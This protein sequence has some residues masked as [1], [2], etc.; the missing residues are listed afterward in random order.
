[1]YQPDYLIIKNF[2]SIKEQKFE[3]PKGRATL[4]QGVNLDEDEGESN[5]SG[6][7][8]LIEGLY[9][10]ITNLILRD[11]GL[12]M[13]DLIRNGCDSAEL[14]SY[15]TNTITKNT[16]LINREFFRKSSSKL[17]IE[18][19]GVD[20]S[21]KFSSVDEGTKLIFQELGI[22]QD[23]LSNYYIVNKE[24][25]TSFFK[26]S[27]NKKKDIIARF[28]G[29]SLINGV[30]DLVQVDV[31]KKDGEL[32]RI[33]DEELTINTRIQVYQEQVEKL[34]LKTVEEEKAE[35]IERL[36]EKIRF[37]E[38]E[39]KEKHYKIHSINESSVSTKKS[40]EAKKSEKKIHEQQLSELSEDNKVKEKISEVDKEQEETNKLKKEYFEKTVE[41]KNLRKETERSLQE[42]ETFLK[43]TELNISGSIECP[44]CSFEFLPGDSEIDVS[45]AKTM[46]PEIKEGILGIE[47]EL[48]VCN[49]EINKVSEKV[50]LFDK[51]L[52]ELDKTR[53]LYREEI[54]K[55][56]R[57]K[58]SVE[59]KIL[60]CES[61]IKKLE[62]SIET[63]NSLIEQ[64]E[65][66]IE[67]INQTISG[68]N[69]QIEEV[70]KKKI[71]RD[72]KTIE[73]QIEDC[74]EQLI[75]INELKQQVEQEKFDI[76]Q[77]KHNFVRF[78]S[79]LANKAIKSIEGFTNYFLEMSKC[80]LQIQMEGYKLLADGKTIREKITTQVLR[81]G[82]SEGVI[83]KFSKG[84]KGK[85]EVCSIVALQQLI[86]LSSLTGGVD[87]CFCDEITESID[88][89]GI[90]SLIQSLD[91]LHKTILV[92][93][94]SSHEKVYDNI[95]TVVK[96]NGISKIF[97]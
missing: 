73:K 97:E 5:G 33:Y 72:T 11:K 71:E 60:Y 67:S 84:E 30:E 83:G 93:T 64:T 14:E 1:M 8:I 41:L 80:N 77:W 78:R 43:K 3:F 69:V 20:Q 39:L 92:I 68:I 88:R 17:R 62:Q 9:T 26:L 52:S 48:N 55:F 57:M 12:V 42:F 38:N 46:I 85:I 7:S 56:Q 10:C 21:D 58:Q 22:T 27:D 90:E 59:E 15:F 94:H 79:Y 4:I 13:V 86:N 32:K 34:N 44:K 61:S 36:E 51:K 75:V 16:L 28:S 70:K 63:N 31:D 66:Q 6:K 89:T 96:E 53:E 74:Q 35:E 95:V 40:I 47:L 49:E 87:L 37:Y 50:S 19:N 76:E 18:I 45:E 91:N 24:N 25:Y 23:D 82:M 54:R 81:N 65:K 2:L 29:A